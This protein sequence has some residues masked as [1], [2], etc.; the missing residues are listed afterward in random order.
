MKHPSNLQT[1]AF[2][3]VEYA[4][5]QVKLWLNDADLD[6]FVFDNFFPA[7]EDPC[8]PMLLCCFTRSSQGGYFNPY[9]PDLLTAYPGEVVQV[10]GPV[11][12]TGNLVSA[13]D[14]RSLVERR[15]PDNNF[16]LFTPQLDQ[17]QQMMYTVIPFKRTPTGDVFD[18]SSLNTNP[19]PP[20][21]AMVT[22]A[23]S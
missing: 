20:A 13:E 12:L 23:V 5:Q 19:S 4:I 2:Y 15:D 16:L 11:K 21:T 7:T 1:L 18:S 17:H 22:V 3:R 14:M 8:R 6:Y 10:E 9:N